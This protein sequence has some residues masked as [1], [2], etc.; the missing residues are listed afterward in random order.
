MGGWASLGD[1]PGGLFRH[2]QHHPHLPGCLS[3]QHCGD[4]ACCA[5]T[6]VGFSSGTHAASLRYLGDCAFPGRCV[7]AGGGKSGG[8]GVKDFV[9]GA[10]TG[11][12]LTAPLFAWMAMDT[13]LALG[14]PGTSLWA[15]HS[16][17]L[18]FGL[19]FSVASACCSSV[20]S[21][22]RGGDSAL[23]STKNPAIGGV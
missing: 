2:V 13:I 9:F 5:V 12:F 23:A 20:A 11:S 3:T 16:G 17:L 22:G 14:S 15:A 6:T 8:I 18:R 21:S 19:V 10:M 7:G 1:H 4:P